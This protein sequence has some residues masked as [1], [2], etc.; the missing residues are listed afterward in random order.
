MTV[1]SALIPVQARVF[2][3]IAS[4]DAIAGDLHDLAQQFGVAPSDFMSCLE[5][6]VR[7]DWVTVVPDPEGFFRVRL[8]P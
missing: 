7:A 6:L 5:E 1:G 8:K 4:N 2:E 3:V